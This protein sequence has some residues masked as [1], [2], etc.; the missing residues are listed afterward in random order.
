MRNA[1]SVIGAKRTYECWAR[2]DRVIHVSIMIRCPNCGERSAYEF[3]FGG[4]VKKRPQVGAPD[5]EWYDYVY[6]KD[7]IH[8]VQKEWCYHSLGC[9]HWFLVVRDTSSNEVL[10]T[11]PPA[12]DKLKEW[13]I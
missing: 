11:F 9:R 6:G 8:G 12:D 7:N 1:I 4:E 5:A 3:L 2:V 10:E 13:K